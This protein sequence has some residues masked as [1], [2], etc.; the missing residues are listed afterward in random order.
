MPRFNGPIPALKTIIAV[1]ISLLGALTA[2]S[3]H[4]AF[5]E[6]EVLL[7]K[8]DGSTSA[9]SAAE[10]HS[11][12][13]DL[14]LSGSK[15]SSDESLDTDLG[16]S[17][18][19]GNALYCDGTTA[20]ATHTDH[21]TFEPSD[22][23]LSMWVYAD[24]FSDCN[25]NCTLV[26][27]G[28][29]ASNPSGYWLYT[30]NT[31]ALSVDIA[32]GGSTS[33][34]SGG[35]LSTGVWNH[36]VVT[37]KNVTVSLY[38][39]GQHQ[40]LS[41]LSHYVAYGSDDFMLCGIDTSTDYFKGYLDD[42]R[43]FN[44]DM[45]S[46][47]VAEFY[48]W[49]TDSD[50]DGYNASDDCDMDSAA[51]YPGATEYCDSVDN[52]CDGT[53][54]EDSA[55]DAATWYADA[56]TDGYG[57][58][59]STTAACSAPTGY[60]S[61]DTD[62][63]DAE[64]TTNPGASE[65]C[66][67]IDNDCDA[68]VDEDS[69][70]DALLWYT[71]GDGDGYGDATASSTACSQPSGSVSDNTDCDDTD[72]S[73]HPTADEYCDGHD[74]DCDGIT[75]EN[76]AVDAST[77][78]A[79]TD[80]DTYGDPAVSQPACTQPTNYVSDNTDCND[81]AFGINP[82]VDEYCDGHDDD[83][84][85]VIDEDDSLDAST[86]YADSD[87]DGYGD[88]SATTDS[89]SQPSGYVSD[90]TDCNDSDS[91]IS[92]AGT[93]ICD[94]AD[95]DCD[96]DTDEDSAADVKTWYADSDT[97]GYGDV[98]STDI[99]CDQPSGFVADD[100]D[101]DDTDAATN[102]GASELCDSIDNNCDGTIDENSAVDALSWYADSDADG[103]GDPTNT[104]Q[105]CSQPSNYLSD[106]TDCDD[107]NS[108]IYPGATEYCDTTDWDCDGDTQDDDASDALTWFADT[109][110]DGFGDPNNTTLACTEPSGYGADDTDC[111]DTD[112]AIHPTATEI[113][114]DGVDQNCDNSSDYDQDGDTYDYWDYDGDDC[115]DEDA[116]VNPD[117][118]EIYYDGI[119]QDCDEASDYD[120]DGDGF[121][122]E[123]YGGDDCDDA[124]EDIYPGAP[125]TPYDGLIHDCNHAN[126]YDA[127]GDGF[128]TYLFGG[129]D[130][131]DGNSAIHPDAEEIWYDGLD[132]NCDENDDDQDEDGYALADDCDDED[133]DLYPNAP[134]LDEDCNPLD[135]AGD[136]GSS[137]TDSGNVSD[138][139]ETPGPKD[140][141]G[142]PDPDGGGGC[143]CSSG[144]RQPGHFIWLAGILG[145][146]LQRRRSA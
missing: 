114:Y 78:Y 124:D 131:D 5:A 21:S 39:D 38:I 85:G 84:D 115:D 60:V 71:D 23:T 140:G 111:N 34:V 81:N 57:D 48:D 113:W 138:T 13:L 97:D 122:S 108:A 26:S 19:S 6:D 40:V 121:D 110:L 125:D 120:S 18:D 88:A 70:T 72:G 139:G 56:D 90:N 47:E 4:A 49:Y 144:E 9:S 77:W 29:N 52:N 132:Q 103:F 12:G 83:C 133:P 128:Q 2:S 25:G 145:L 126:D 95:N 27:K 67:G 30:D 136:T 28:S 87:A 44:G 31:G 63:D 106:D 96:G 43:L 1:G 82:G 64:A 36:V 54:D 104:T 127:D 142:F 35:T 116:L 99:D 100:T 146:V 73:T 91:S 135:T 15:I 32:N 134:G 143:A 7:Y 20:T 102:P 8:F 123:T 68:T 17:W 109:D 86:Y 112:I 41:N 55:A 69:A 118:T 33:T 10:T 59:T 37:L 65:T 107:A 93:E 80:N 16:N 98:N 11:T 101:C 62:C 137:T 53:V 50:G 130:C 42:F 74:D 58:A 76:D 141:V 51:T 22:F 61:D 79:D 66:D 75:D 117:A 89:C 94:S 129:D 46:T 14:T 105:S 3:A 119:D 92:P 45:S 24:N